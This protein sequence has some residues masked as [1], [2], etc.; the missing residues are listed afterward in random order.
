MRVDRPGSSS[1]DN[2]ARVVRRGV[3]LHAPAA[4]EIS[5]LRQKHATIHRMGD[6]M[7]DAAYAHGFAAFRACAAADNPKVRAYSRH[8]G[9]TQRGDVRL[10]DG[11]AARGSSGGAVRWQAP[12][13][14]SI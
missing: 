13:P 4:P 8:A 6:T 2:V 12:R 1:P 9:C 7:D 11:T 10:I 3:R 14:A 5:D